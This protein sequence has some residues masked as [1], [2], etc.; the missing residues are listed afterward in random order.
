MEFS[1]IEIGACGA[2]LL[3]ILGAIGVPIA[4]AAAISGTL[5]LVAILGWEAG[6]RTAGTIPHAKGVSYTL[7][8]LPMFILLGYLAHFAGITQSAFETCRRWFGRL[9]GGLATATIDRM[10]VPEDAL[11]LTKGRYPVLGIIPDPS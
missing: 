2:A 3:F 4:Y 6:L 5:G 9:P 1:R 8:V 11:R 10:H 7:S